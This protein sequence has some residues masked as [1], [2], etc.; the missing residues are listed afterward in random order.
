MKLNQQQINF[1]HTFGYLIVRCALSRLETVQIIEAF[2]W[3]IQKFGGG[4]DRDGSRR[5]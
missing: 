4:V 3:P 5:T 1:F 2:E